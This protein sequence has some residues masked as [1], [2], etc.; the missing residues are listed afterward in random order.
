MHT[1]Y[2]I[3]TTTVLIKDDGSWGIQAYTTQPIKDLA[4][5]LQ[6]VHHIRQRS[7]TLTCTWDMVRVTTP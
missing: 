3:S 6:T 1:A 4:D 7:T 5:V 2:T